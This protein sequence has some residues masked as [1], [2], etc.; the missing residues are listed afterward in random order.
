MLPNCSQSQAI[1][2]NIRSLPNWKSIV[3]F[4][5]WSMLAMSCFIP[6][7]Y[8]VF[9]NGHAQ[10]WSSKS[11]K[12][13]WGFNTHAQFVS[14]CS[15]MET[16]H[17]EVE[18]SFFENRIISLKVQLESLSNLLHFFV[19]ILNIWKM[20][21]KLNFSFSSFALSSLKREIIKKK[22]KKPNFTIHTS[23]N[24]IFF[25]FK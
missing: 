24:H 22:W 21:K 3:L 11:I 20:L 6:C 8:Y 17:S 4:K 5:K 7:I 23:S 2:V 14:K 25:F 1:L 19:Y 9:T 12:M 13:I 15:C 16:A 10:N 18:S